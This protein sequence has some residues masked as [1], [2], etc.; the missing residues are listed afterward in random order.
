MLSPA[1]SFVKSAQE[2]ASLLFKIQTSAA[3]MANAPVGPV[4]VSLVIK[5]LQ[6]TDTTILEAGGPSPREATLVD[7]MISRT[8]KIIHN[9]N[10]TW[11]QRNRHRLSDLY[12]KKDAHEF[13]S[14]KKVN[15]LG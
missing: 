2:A 12:K 10:Q 14:Q 1:S 15:K 13:W 7:K 4:V 9:K 5:L 3:A 6:I 11:P 8:S